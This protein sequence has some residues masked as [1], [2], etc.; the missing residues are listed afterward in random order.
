MLIKSNFLR[1]I[2][3][4]SL[5]AVIA[6]PIYNIFFL[7]PAFTDF[8][9]KNTESSLIQV[10]SQMASEL[11]L[12]E[13]EI[14]SDSFPD[15]FQDE[16]ERIRKMLGLWKVKVY[17]ISGEML[18]SSPPDGTGYV[19]KGGDFF[20]EIVTDRKPNALVIKKV[21]DANEKKN[22]EMTLIETYVPITN[23]DKVVGVFEIYSDITDSKLDLDKLRLRSNGTLFAISVMLLL[24]VFV[25]VKKANR[26]IT[27]RMKIEAEREKLIQELQKALTEVKKLSGF[28]PICASCKKIRDDQGYWNQIEEYIRTHSEAEFSHGICPECSKRLYP[29]FRKIKD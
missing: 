7:T 12:V 28:L 29:N 9:A 2:I 15:H 25:S 24:A 27:E 17:S 10:A 16:L 8:I 21:T 1:W 11:V 5:A 23:G 6:L 3:F 22:G 19:K 4:A 14:T 20:R 26:N 13:S 18:Y